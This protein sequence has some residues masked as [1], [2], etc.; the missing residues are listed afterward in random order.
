VLI[1]YSYSNLFDGDIGLNA[2]ELAAA[3]DE[4]LSQWAAVAPLEFVEVVDQGPAPS[5]QGYNSSGIPMLRFGHHHIAGAGVLAHAYPPGTNGLSGDVHFD[6]DL[7]WTVLPD[8]TA[9]PGS[10]D[11]L[12][13]AVHE[14]GHALGLGHEPA[15]PAGNIALMNPNYAGRFDGL[16]TSFLLPDDVNGIRTIYGTGV[17]SVT[18]LGGRGTAV[19]LQHLSAG[20][21]FENPS[22]LQTHAGFWDSQKWL[23][24]DFNG[25]RKAD[26][27]NLYGNS[28]GNTRAWLHL[29]TG[30]GFEYQSNLQT[31]A[32]FW[33][34]Q[35]WVV[36]D[37]NGDGKDDL[38]NLY[39]NSAG[40]TRAW[41]HFSTGSGFEYQSNL[42]TLAGFWDTQKW[43]AGDFNGDGKDDLVNLYG[44]SVGNT[45]AWLH[46]STGS[47]F[48]YQ[49]NLQTLAGFWDAQKWMVGDFNGDKKDDLVNVYGRSD[50]S[51]RAWIHFSTGSGFEYQSGLQ[52]LAGFWDSQVWTVGDFNG[53]GKD[54]LVNIYERSDGRARTW[55]HFSTGSAFEYQSNLQT[56]SRVWESQHWFAGDFDGDGLADLTTVFS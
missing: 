52:T 26:L 38:V 24:G 37:F 35:K 46:L 25:D 19:T 2:A 23:S 14:I 39:G 5:D 4:A 7:V 12:E 44:N 36:G 18:P 9:P 49:S 3:I 42:Q 43:L 15:P 11:F 41:L 27:V 54:D 51:A 28:A 50:G 1:T 56:L 48:E 30:S 17:G 34:T 31:L 32:G 53:D 29:S 8:A 16:G 20:V 45:R 55:L 22:N 40:N 33:D 47:R 10:F 6:N 21:G 13:V